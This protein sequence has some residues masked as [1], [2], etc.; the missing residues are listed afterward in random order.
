MLELLNDVD[1]AGTELETTELDDRLELAGILELDCP[2]ELLEDGGAT[3][4][5]TLLD[6]AAPPQVPADTLP[7]TVMASILAIACEPVA[8]KRK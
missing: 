6:E 3:D 2:A 7:R 4:E 1:E 8:R 5:A